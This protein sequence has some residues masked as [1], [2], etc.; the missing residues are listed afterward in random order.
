MYCLVPPLWC[1]TSIAAATAVVASGKQSPFY[2][3]CAEGL[4]GDQSS[5]SSPAAECYLRDVTAH[6]GPSQIFQGWNQPG[7]RLPQRIRSWLPVRFGEGFC[8]SVSS[9]SR[10]RSARRIG[11]SARQLNSISSTNPAAVESSTRRLARSTGEVK[12]EE[13]V[14][15]YEFEEGKYVIVDASE[16]EKIRPPKEKGINVAS[17]VADG[18]IDIRYF[19]GKNYH[20]VPDLWDHL[21][22]T[23]VVPSRTRGTWVEPKLYCL[24]RCMERTPGGQLRAPVFGGLHG[25]PDQGWKERPRRGK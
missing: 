12:S 8:A 20:L 2:R 5:V 16:I 25:G 15:G 14:T 11:A 21:R 23:P 18:S 17:S 10:S 19:T 13:I 22:E 7:R 6:A 9:P 4:S 3:T 1:F 24:V